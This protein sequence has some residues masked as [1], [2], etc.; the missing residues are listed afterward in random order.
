MPEKFNLQEHIAHGVEKIVSDV[1]KTTIKNPR[2]SAFMLKFAAASRSAT[3]T[4]R[5]LE[6]EGLNVPSFLIASITSSCN[7]HCDGCYS[8]FNQATTDSEPVRQLSDQEW[9]AIFREAEELGISFI[10]LAGGEP[11]LRRDILENAGKMQN[12]LFPIFTNGTF[13]NSQYLDLFDKC[14]NLVPVISIEGRQEVTDNRRGMGIYEILLQKMDSFHELNLLYG[15]SVTVSKANLREVT[16]PE[17]IGLLADKGCRL[18]FFIEHVPVTADTR[19]LAPGEAE[20]GYLNEAM[21]K[22]R[23]LY[24]DLILLA[25][26]GDERADGGCMAAGRGFFHINSHGDAE[27]CP[28]SPYSDI[29]VRDTS[30]REALESRLF[31]ALRDGDFLDD[32]HVGGCVLFEKRDQVENLLAS[33]RQ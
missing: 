7:L 31:R 17:F 11:L 1:L 33:A 8:R 28:F 9:L 19:D 15:A 18:V 30:L 13:I 4:R 32:D 26:P 12:I 29:N 16:S 24:P 23:E 21:E 22:L 27:P 3:K 6:K 2:E 5:R 20:R 10:M 14:R 25:F